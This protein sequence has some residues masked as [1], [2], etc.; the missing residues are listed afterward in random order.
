MKQLQGAST[1]FDYNALGER[2][3]TISVTAG[4]TLD[5]D[6]LN[7]ML[8]NVVLLDKYVINL[9]TESTENTEGEWWRSTTSIFYKPGE[10][11]LTISV[12]RTQLTGLTL[13]N[14]SC[15]ISIDADGNTIINT[16][17]IDP[18][19]AAKVAKSVDVTFNTTNVSY[20]VAGYETYSSNSLGG[21]TEHFYDGFA[22]RVRTTNYA[23]GREL[24]SVTTYHDD[25]SVA[26]ISE[27][28]ASG[29][30]TTSY[31]VR[32]VVVDKPGAYKTTVT[33]AKGNQTVN[34]YSGNG[35]LYRSEGATYPTET[36]FDAAGRM[37]ELHT[38]RN[39]N[40]D[41]DIT[42]WYYDL[43]TGAVTNKL[44]ADGKGTAY[45]YLSDGR[46]STRKW[47]RNIITTY[48][49]ADTATGSIR[50][51]EYNDD[52]PNVTNYYNLIGQLIKVEDGTGTTTFGYDSKGR[53]IAETNAFA[54]ITRSYNTYGRYAEFILT[55]A[56][57]GHP[58]QKIAF[59]YDAKNRLN[60][61]TSIVGTE[62]NTFI[63]SYMSGTTLITGYTGTSSTNPQSQ[64]QIL[65]SF[66]PNRD[67]ISA[68]TNTFVSS[69][70][71]VVSSFNYSNDS[72]G[73]RSSRTDYYNGSTVIN[74]FD[75]ND[76]KEVTNAVMNYTE[77]SIAYDDIGNRQTSTVNSVPSIYI[78]NQ[79][80]QYTA[81][82]SGISASPT[83]DSDG[84]L[85]WD[86]QKWDHSWDGENRLISSVPDYWGTTNGA[87]MF[88]YRYN[89]QNLRVEKVKKQ[90]SGRDPGYPMTPGANPGIWNPIETRRYI[91]DGWNIAA[92]IIIDHVTP[93][94]NISY[95]TWGLDLSGTLQGAGGVGGLLCDTKVSSSETNTYFAVGDANGNITEYI[96]NT[97]A[98]AAH[99]EH[100]AFGETKFSGA[101]KDA[102]THWFSTKP[103]DE[104]TRF[105]A[106]QQRYY[107]P[108]LCWWLSRDPITED[109]GKN[110]YLLGNNDAIN[111]WDY[112]GKSQTSDINIDFSPMIK[113]KYE[114][115]YMWG[116]IFSSQLKVVSQNLPGTAPY[117]RRLSNRST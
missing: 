88:E 47:A 15:S 108:I 39:Q 109:G 67:L 40:G 114:V 45:T 79:L 89:H 5:F 90:L 111:K 23:N 113:W 64:I 96:D 29:T 48:G 75:Y 102:F 8:A 87:C 70:P 44:Y 116:K 100:N 27:V 115:Q 77:Q 71:Y 84:N 60:A 11:A 24:K 112:L 103:F 7:F 41:S 72:I 26:A 97:G 20:Y 62:T 95:Y 98:V 54:V 80:N 117:R 73:Q 22:R 107:D 17:S 55:P 4:Q 85:T 38:W 58:V 59:G 91:W 32:Q 13:P 21:V 6:P 16:E 101:M 19:N 14:N 36:A 52:T 50:T 25:G 28:T 92:E 78:A 76:R 105:V 57:P 37:A 104:Q 110:L 1:V 56:N 82:T 68:V 2:T 18:A 53:L 99:G 33:D 69:V 61:L 34:Y 66:E 86:G 3:A 35:Q 12:H 65:K 46:I 49:Y 43:F 9:T 106:Y 74:N 94:T 10:N 81:I 31:S 83:H 51:T 63:Y 93:G 42:R 30:N